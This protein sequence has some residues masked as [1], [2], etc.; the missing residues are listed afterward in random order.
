[1]I[2]GEAFLRGVSTRAFWRDLA[3]WLRVGAAPVLEGRPSTPR[4]PADPWPETGYL[5]LDPLLDLTAAASLA[6][7]AAALHARGIHPTFIYVYDEAWQVLDAL[8]PRLAPLL[9]PDVEPLADVWGWCIDPRTDPG[10]WP[11]HRGWYEDVRDPS[12][13]PGLVNVWLSLTSA[14]ERNACMHLVPLPRDRHY[15]SSLRDLAGLDALGV[16][17]PTS[18]GSALVWNANVAHW[19]GAC[20]PTFTEPRISMSF[21]LRRPGHP[22]ALAPLPR[23]L[24][25]AERLDVI[26]DQIETY[27]RKELAA[28]R[29]ELR[30]AE[31]VCGMR[32]MAGRAPKRT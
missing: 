18:A 21:T 16:A 9:G 26:A 23:P 14:S 2:P 19:G 25:F 8:L 22:T 30:W 12:G 27:G 28:D 29:V 17:L 5:R 31:M 11:L 13:V 20:D 15:P 4:A 10:G 1:M 32:R 6:R 7:A 3:P 24:G